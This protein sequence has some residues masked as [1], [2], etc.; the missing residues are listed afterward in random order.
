M[1]LILEPR[2]MKMSDSNIILNTDWLS[3]HQVVIGGHQ[4]KEITYNDDD[5]DAKG[6]AGH[7]SLCKIA[8]TAVQKNGNYYFIFLNLA[9]DLHHWTCFVFLVNLS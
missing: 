4:K 7:P 8:M 9:L 1:R 3:V 6:I 5:D 2:G